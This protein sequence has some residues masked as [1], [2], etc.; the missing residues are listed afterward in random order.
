MGPAI[1]GTSI[2]TGG[3]RHKP[4]NPFNKNGEAEDLKVDLKEA[5]PFKK[6]GKSDVALLISPGTQKGSDPESAAVDAEL[7]VQIFQALQKKGV[8]KLMKPRE[9][10]HGDVIRLSTGDYKDVTADAVMFARLYSKGGGNF[11][12]VVRREVGGQTTWKNV[13]E[14]NTLKPSKAGLAKLANIV[15]DAYVGAIHGA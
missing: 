7:A 11:M 13:Y 15:A 12:E 6:E 3:F 2:V 10:G 1:L 4:K 14:L 9:M 8:P 5:V